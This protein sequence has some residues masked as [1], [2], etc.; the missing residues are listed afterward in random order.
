VASHR[1]KLVRSAVVGFG[2][3]REA[4]RLV[5]ASG[6]ARTTLGTIVGPG[7]DRF[8]LHDVDNGGRADLH[9]GTAAIALPFIH[10]WQHFNP[11]F[12]V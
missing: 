7:N 10:N 11:P 9:A 8:V 12:F 5:G 4:Y 1:E 6:F 3:S 2:S